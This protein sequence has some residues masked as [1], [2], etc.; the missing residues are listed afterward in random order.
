MN[1]GPASANGSEPGAAHAHDHFV[2]FYDS[3]TFLI[4]SMARFMGPG[5]KGSDAAVM[6]GTQE[7][8]DALENA[9]TNA[10]VD[11][12]AAI[13]EGRY[14]AL[15]ASEMLSQFM[16]D[17]LP[18][19]IRFMQ[20]VGDVV[21]RAAATGHRV[22]IFGEMVALLWAEGNMAGA[23]ALEELWNELAHTHPF[24]LFCAYP[25]AAF[26]KDA[27]ADSFSQVLDTH[28]RVI[29][30][31]SYTEAKDPDERLRK[32]ALLQQKAASEEARAQQLAAEI[33]RRQALELNDTVVQG[34]TVA[35]LALETGEVDKGLEAVAGTLVTAQSIVASLLSQMEQA[36]G[37]P[38]KP[39]DLVR[40][41]GSQP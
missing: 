39:G 18:D 24:T 16:V 3:D 8:R 17:R 5:L 36:N 22:R 21:A 12:P 14:V 26:A 33:E 41:N 35:K 4:G 28:V 27:S 20:T 30:T 1:G 40:E 13:E 19:P 38:L 37:G 32:I 29:P 2:Q 23:I 7:H 6:V 9:L 34:L 31:E 11:L 25:L 15:D 10:G